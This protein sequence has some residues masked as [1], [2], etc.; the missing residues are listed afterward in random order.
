MITGG[1]IT[2]NGVRLVLLT[3][4]SLLTG[5]CGADTNDGTQ[6]YDD[7]IDLA[8]DLAEADGGPICLFKN[9]DADETGLQL[10]ECTTQGTDWTIKMWDGPAERDA[11]TADLLNIFNVSDIDYCLAIGEGAGAWSVNV[12]N[13]P[14]LC[15]T[16]ATALGVSPTVSDQSG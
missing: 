3:A 9:S 12:D 14:A 15:R 6:T 2:V 5:A 4:A 7:A 8:N 10:A 1:G 13:D 16:I 11:G